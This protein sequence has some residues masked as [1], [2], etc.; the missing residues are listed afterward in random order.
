MKFQNILE[1]Y[2][3]RTVLDELAYYGFRVCKNKNTTAEH[4]ALLLV[5]QKQRR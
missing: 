1:V 4:N 2:N 3:V 5:L